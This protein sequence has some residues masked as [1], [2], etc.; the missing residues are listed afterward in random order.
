M[1]N[2]HN[3]RRRR[4]EHFLK[5]LLVILIVSIM[6]LLMW[7]TLDLMGPVVHTALD[8]SVSCS[9]TVTNYA[10]KTDNISIVHQVLRA[11]I[12]A[13]VLIRWYEQLM[14]NAM[15][16]CIVRFVA[17]FVVFA[18]LD[19]VAYTTEFLGIAFWN[20]I[21]SGLDNIQLMNI[22]ETQYI[23]RIDVLSRLG[24]AFVATNVWYLIC[25]V[26]KKGKSEEP[27][28]VEQ[29]VEQKVHK[30]EKLFNCTPEG[31]Y[32]VTL[33]SRRVKL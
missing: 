23:E 29:H 24:Q 9:S 13:L 26:H 8:A 7:C 28:K 30:K 12:T 6:M 15:Y 22:I 18:I 20:A 32:N 19:F 31:G 14:C 17:F 21:S 27:K 2:K 3:S 25:R 33:P 16:N 10:A 5:E 11:I 1:M 4:N